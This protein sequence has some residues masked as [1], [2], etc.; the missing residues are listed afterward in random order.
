MTPLSPAYDTKIAWR[1]S[2]R[3][4]EH[5]VENKTALQKE[6][7]WPM[8]PKVPVVCLPAGMSDEL[9]G[10]LLKELLPGLL[11]MSLELLVLGKGNAAY[12]ELF[13]ELARERGHRIAI[14][15]NEDDNLRKM[16]AASDIAFFLADP[17]SMPE[18]TSCLQYGVVPIAPACKALNDYNPVQE[19]GNAFLAPDE[20]SWLL[21]ASLVRALETFK[22]PFDWRT[23][24]R[25]GMET[26]GGTKE[27]NEG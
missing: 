16:L 6:L 10:A 26:M 2:A 17:D 22:F 23:I 5:K 1:Y 25:H 21:F 19:T 20:T 24:Q 11:S 12:G 7:G 8:E 18:L 9:G 27:E 14:I 15:P 13:T 4:I 3:T